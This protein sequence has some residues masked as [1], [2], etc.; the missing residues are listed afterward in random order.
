MAIVY[1]G[2]RKAGKTHLAL[3]L[4]NPRG[5]YVKVSGIDYDSL[6]ANLF[7]TEDTIRATDSIREH[8][9]EVNVQ[10]PIPKPLLV[11]WMDTPGEIWRSSW[12]TDNQED[13]LSFLGTVTQSEGVLLILPPYREILKPTIDPQ[14]Y[15]TQRQWCNRFDSWVEF[16]I[17]HCAKARHIAICLNKADLFCDY[18]AEAQKLIYNPNGRQMAWLDRH[19]YVSQR[20]FHP[21]QAQIDR[22][23]T[24]RDCAARCFITSIHSRTLLE[25]PWI[26]LASFL[27]A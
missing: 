10:L 23:N 7:G 9:L 3:E 21:I 13:W 4:I 5:H 26:Y 27:S 16:F 17:S 6:K 15:M 11:K 24:Q 12:Q 14:P 1:I 20:Y 25:L 2:D 19:R 8:P 22:I 18:E